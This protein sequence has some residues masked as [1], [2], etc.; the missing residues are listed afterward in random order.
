MQL[1]SGT[2]EQRIITA[3]KE[4]YPVTMEELIE[5][6]GVKANLV[7]LTVNRLARSGI[8]IIE[9]LPDRTYLR[10]GKAVGFVGINP[11]Q[12]KA[13]KKRGHN[14]K[15]ESTEVVEGYI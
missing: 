10:P 12:K 11:S 3:V 14:K 15:K 6:L 2:L 5:I 7:R 4:N 9:P 13:F 1:R 8:I